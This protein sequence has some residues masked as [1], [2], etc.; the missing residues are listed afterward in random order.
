M[1]KKYFC[2]DESSSQPGKY[3]IHIDLNAFPSNISTTGSYNLLSARLLHLSYADYLRYCRDI[4][5][6]EIIGKNNCYPIAYFKNNDKSKSLINILNKR[7][8]MI[9][10]HWRK[11]E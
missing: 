5:G 6:A 1:T 3:I 11:E 4:C 7:M 9:A 2:L 10:T 8:S